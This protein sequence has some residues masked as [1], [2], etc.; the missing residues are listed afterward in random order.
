MKKII[1]T[2]TINAP[3]KAIRL[4]DAMTDWQFVVIGDL[5][6]PPDYRLRARAVCRPC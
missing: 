1:A 3:T 6:T 5:K 2:T 4:F